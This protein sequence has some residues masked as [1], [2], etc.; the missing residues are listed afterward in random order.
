MFTQHRN[1]GNT[2]AERFHSVGTKDVLL[3]SPLS[4]CFQNVVDP[5]TEDDF[6]SVAMRIIVRYKRFTT[7]ASVWSLF[8]LT[9]LNV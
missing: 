4:L 9:I 7:A 6:V 2:E 5:S 3:F 1:R 8:S